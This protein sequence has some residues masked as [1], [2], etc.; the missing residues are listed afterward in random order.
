MG[1]AEDGV[2]SDLESEPENVWE[3]DS[4]SDS[5]VSDSQSE[6]DI[7]D[8]A[9]GAPL[10]SDVYSA[11]CFLERNWGRAC[12]CEEEEEENE[13]GNV[14]RDGQPGIGLRDMA[15]YWRSLAVPDSIGNA[16]PHGEAEES[17]P[18]QLDWSSVLSGG[19]SR[20]NLDIHLSQTST[21]NIQRTW[22]VDSIISWASCLSVNRGLY[23]SYH[24][25]ISRNFGSSMHV[26]HQGTALHVIPHLRLGSGRQSPQFG[27]YIFFPGISHVCRTTTYLTKNERRMWINELLLPAIRHCCPPDVVQHHPRS[28][29]DVESKAYSRQRETCG[30]MINHK[31]DMHHYLPQEYL[32]QIWHHINQR[33]EQPELA[34][35]RGMFIVLSAKNIKLEA[36]SPTLQQCRAK[37]I[38]HLHQVLDWS[39]ADLSNTWVDVGIEDTAA[40]EKCT[41]LFKSGCLK[42][43]AHSM[44]YSVDKPLMSSECFN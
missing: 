39:K 44:R 43:W 31:M 12:D 3:P 42:S 30:G 8:N 22:D 5:D 20:P 17:D 36:R 27:V 37:I 19:A 6:I 38:A 35:F 21:P 28:F 7:D 13:V 11:K 32:Q 40:S 16:P 24:P 41:F 26:F 33:I 1:G 10:E 18:V 2:A 15:E 9:T 23:V 25:P 29:D 14:S 34:M 4:S